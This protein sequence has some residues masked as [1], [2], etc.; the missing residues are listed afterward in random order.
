MYRSD[1]NDA[2]IAAARWHD[3]FKS[4]IGFSSTLAP[5]DVHEDAITG[6]SSIADA[7]L[8]NFDADNDTAFTP[9]P[10][11][12]MA[13]FITY[14]HPVSKQ[15]FDSSTLN[16]RC[17]VIGQLRCWAMLAQGRSRFCFCNDP[18][19]FTGN[20]AFS[21]AESGRGGQKRTRALSGY[22]TDELDKLWSVNCE[23]MENSLTPSKQKPV[24]VGSVR[25][26]RDEGRSCRQT[27]DLGRREC[28]GNGGAPH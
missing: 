25:S 21:D 8:P 3:I 9:T 17:R 6:Y 24:R 14:S 11:M 13:T 23:W 20:V 28:G 7:D 19:T 10:T 16:L 27:A 22:E 15:L 4:M 2:D 26:G 12:S 1:L 18:F 5:Q